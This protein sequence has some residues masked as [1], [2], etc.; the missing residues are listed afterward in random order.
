VSIKGKQILQPGL[1]DPDLVDL[2]EQAL[3]EGQ[4]DSKKADLAYLWIQAKKI[5]LPSLA[6]ILCGTFYGTK[7]KI[8]C[9]NDYNQ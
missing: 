6:R 3:L 8:I 5:N 9:I 7:Q 4:I 1:P 2:I